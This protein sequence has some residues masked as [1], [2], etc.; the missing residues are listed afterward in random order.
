[1]ILQRDPMKK[2]PSGGLSF[3]CWFD[4]KCTTN[5]WGSFAI[6]L[7]ASLESSRTKNGRFQRVENSTQV[8]T[9]FWRDSPNNKQIY[10]IFIWHV[11][12]GFDQRWKQYWDG[13]FI[14][15]CICLL[16]FSFFV[17][18]ENY[19]LSSRYSLHRTS[20]TK[21]N[22]KVTLQCKQSFPL[23]TNI[24]CRG[25]DKLE[26]ILC[27]I[28]ALRTWSTFENSWRT[29]SLLTSKDVKNKKWT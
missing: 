15:D 5:F 16:S 11:I 6:F 4:E 3:T 23:I 1:M 9:F 14:C 19:D 7:F 28:F 29:F 21:Q 22:N 25:L 18:P 27:D 13:P 8:V 17:S 2:V 12:I 26:I 10:Y 24:D 20:Q